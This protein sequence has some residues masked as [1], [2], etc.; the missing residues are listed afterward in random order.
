VFSYSLLFYKSST[1]QYVD[2]AHAIP[3]DDIGSGTRSCSSVAWA[4]MINIDATLDVGS[5]APR[6]LSQ[7]SHEI[8]HGPDMACAHGCDFDIQ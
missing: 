4:P 7:I 8:G 3:H 1:H 5:T 2:H 6:T